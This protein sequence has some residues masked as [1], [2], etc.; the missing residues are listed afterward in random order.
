[1]NKNELDWHEQMHTNLRKVARKYGFMVAVTQNRGGDFADFI[2]NIDEANMM[3]LKLNPALAVKPFKLFP[4]DKDM[5]LDDIDK[6]LEGYAL[7]HE[8]FQEKS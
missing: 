8:S 1:M 6:F 4:Y 7:P 3:G 5:G 2:I